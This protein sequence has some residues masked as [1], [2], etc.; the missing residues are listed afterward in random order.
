MEVPPAF[1]V[2]ILTSCTVRSNLG[3]SLSAD[4]VWIKTKCRRDMDRMNTWEYV[5]L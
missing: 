3:V 4:H 1:S 5:Y 2:V